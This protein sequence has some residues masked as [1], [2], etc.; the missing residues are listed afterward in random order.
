MLTKKWGI[1][2]GKKSMNEKKTNKFT[3]KKYV[4]L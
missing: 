2:H 3:F 1:I 4:L